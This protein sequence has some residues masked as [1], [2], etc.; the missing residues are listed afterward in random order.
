[1]LEVYLSFFEREREEWGIFFFRLERLRRQGDE[2]EDI[3][4]FRL[5]CFVSIREWRGG[6][7][8]FKV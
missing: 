5:S 2:G 3:E 1:M 8:Q 7:L 6:M 4:R